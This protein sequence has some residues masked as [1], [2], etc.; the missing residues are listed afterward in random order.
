[1][2]RAQSQR[3]APEQGCSKVGLC[4]FHTVAAVGRKPPKFWFRGGLSA[5]LERFW[6]RNRGESA[7]FPSSPSLESFKRLSMNNLPT[8]PSV[9]NP[10]AL[11]RAVSSLFKPGPR[12]IKPN[13]GVFQ[14]AHSATNGIETGTKSRERRK[15]GISAIPV[16]A[17]GRN[18]WLCSNP[19]LFQSPPVQNPCPAKLG[20]VCPARKLAREGGARYGQP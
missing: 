17:E 10:K 13:Q 7:G 15:N 19:L 16:S 20:C 11:L 6:R 1:M 12:I 9:S 5:S 2:A 14:F 8:K 18:R 3:G 4:L